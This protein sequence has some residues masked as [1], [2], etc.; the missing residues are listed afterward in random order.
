MS[1]NYALHNIANI[2]WIVKC[3]LIIYFPNG[4]SKSFWS[5]IFNSYNIKYALHIKSTLIGYNK[6]YY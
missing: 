5:I 2:Y 6:L 1:L 4:V 3:Y